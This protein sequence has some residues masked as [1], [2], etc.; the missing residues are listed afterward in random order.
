MMGVVQHDQASRVCRVEAV[1][2]SSGPA[3]SGRL[4]NEVKNQNT[5][6]C[7]GLTV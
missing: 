3:A 2:E 5:A 4:N 1:A 7:G 6:C